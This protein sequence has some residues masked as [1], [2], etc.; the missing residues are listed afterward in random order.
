M[1]NYSEKEREATVQFISSTISKC[2]KM[3]P[4]FAEGTS[5][6]SLLKNRIR[7]LNISKALIEEDGNV[8]TFTQLDLEKAMPPV[9]SIISKSEKAQMKY[10]EGTVQYRRYTPSLSAMYLA[11]A[12]IEKALS[13]RKL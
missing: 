4:K 8:E 9:L 5:Q 3:L 10:T 2:D 6:H 7:A 1:E 11:K 13:E 12:Y